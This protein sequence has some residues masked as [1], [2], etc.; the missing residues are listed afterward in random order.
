[1]DLPVNKP[2]ILNLAEAPS[3]EFGIPLRIKRSLKSTSQEIDAGEL[4]EKLF[5]GKSWFSF[6]TER[7]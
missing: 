2:K 7:V 5:G 1:M 6:I 3:D 4:H